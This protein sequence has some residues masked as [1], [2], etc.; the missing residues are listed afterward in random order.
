MSQRPPDIEIYVKRVD[1]ESIQNWLKEHF[2]V[3]GRE[4]K[5]DAMEL[6]LAFDEVRLDCIIVERA[7]KGGYTSVWFKQNNTPGDSDEA[8]ALAAHN[9]LDAE[10]RCSISGWQTGDDDRG[11]WYRFTNGERSTVNWLA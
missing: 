10:T 4:T 1:L 11:G 8:C 3:E 7:V 2:I 5:G 6:R 9:Y